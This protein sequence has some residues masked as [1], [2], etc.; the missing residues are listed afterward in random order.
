MTPDLL[1]HALTLAWSAWTELGVPGTER[2]HAHVAADPEPLLVA[3]PTLSRHDARLRDELNRWCAAHAGVVSVSRL[4]GLVRRAPPDVRAAFGGL[5]AAV[6][7]A[8]PTTPDDPPW[9]A[10]P[11]GRVPVLRPER[12]SLARLRLRAVAGIGARADVLAALLARPTAWVTAADLDHLGYSK[13]NVARLLSELSDARVADARGERN[14]RVFRLAHPE[15]WTDL[16][17]LRGLAWPRWDLVFDLVLAALALADL[18]TKPAT[19]RRVEATA[20]QPRL[21]DL[22]L[23]L[24]LPPPAIARGDPDAWPALLTWA[25]T[26][27]R[28]LSRGE[29]PV[30]AAPPSPAALAPPEPSPLAADYQAALHPEVP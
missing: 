28:A 12:P 19:V 1:P 17:H 11:T 27:L 14:T 30:F 16:L 4:Q 3:T 2:H 15:R 25:D 21:A 13:R 24:D 29:T 10:A 20:A 18:H 6:Q 9:P 7:P 26:T 22:A 23:A 5:A 8:W